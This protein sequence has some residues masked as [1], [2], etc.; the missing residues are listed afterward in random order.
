MTTPPPVPSP[1]DPPPGGVAFAQ[2]APDEIVA[3]GHHVLAVEPTGAEPVPPEGR[4]G[5]PLQLLW[6]WTSPNMEFATVFIGVLAVGIF[7]L[8]FW[9]ATLAIVIGTVIGS[10]AHGFLGLVGPRF[11]VPQMVAGR[12]GFG[13]YGNA[14]PSGLNA[15]TAGIGWF[16]VNSVS[17]S[18][19]LNSL[20]HIPLLLCLFIVVVVQIAIAYLGHNFVQTAEKYTFPVLTVIFLV[21]SVVILTKAHPAAANG[22]HALPGAFLLTVGAAFGYAAGWNPY[23]A[24]YTRYL[25]KATARWKV[26]LWPGVGVLVSCVLLEI[27][28]AA[29]ATLVAPAHASPTDAFIHPLPTVLAKLT[30]LAIVIGGIAANALN[31]YSGTLS[32]VAMGLRLPAA[33]RRAAASL[34]FGV[35]GTVLAWTG[36]T[37]SGERYENFL[38]VITYWIGPWLAVTF[39]DRWLNR[40]RPDEV[41]ARIL[42]DTSHR[43][44]AGPV[45]MAVGTALGIVLFSNQTDFQGLVAKHVPGIG[46]IAFAAG[47]AIA[48]IVYVA[49]LR[50]PGMGPARRTAKA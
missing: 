12:A 6:T 5:K 9:P 4:H 39:L 21:T 28:G 38:L 11:G 41:T 22:A 45:A 16:A 8:G 30:L 3:Y 15:L 32:F 37:D 49:L 33:F 47:F 23:G 26:A 46:D 50:V 27:V 1:G 19:A 10:V 17:A 31:I 48:A 29:S 43:V 44:W 18:Y 13:F 2:A 34:V 14:L 25:P 35:V 20:A 24:D 36:L 7:G 40:S 42:E